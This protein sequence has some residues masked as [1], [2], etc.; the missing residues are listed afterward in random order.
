MSSVKLHAYFEMVLIVISDLLWFMP[1]GYGRKSALVKPDHQQCVL[2][3]L[4]KPFLAMNIS[5]TTQSVLLLSQGVVSL[6]FN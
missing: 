3:A 5:G 2:S 4:L 6:P 1:T